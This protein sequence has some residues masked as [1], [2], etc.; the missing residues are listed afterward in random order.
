[1]NVSTAVHQ[2]LRLPGL[3]LYGSRWHNPGPAPDNA[4]RFLLT[5][6]PLVLM[7]ISFAFSF[8][9]DFGPVEKEPAASGA[10]D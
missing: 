3:H 8:F 9:V 10:A 1:M 7:V 6:F 4:A 5:V 2:L